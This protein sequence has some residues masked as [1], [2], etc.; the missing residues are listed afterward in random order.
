MQKHAICY[1]AHLDGEAVER[2]QKAFKFRQSFVDARLRI[3]QRSSISSNP[4]HLRL[5]VAAQAAVQLIGGVK[6]RRQLRQR[7]SAHT[8]TYTYLKG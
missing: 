4:G 8:Y 3:T 5:A 6:R 1:Q 7:L 2:C